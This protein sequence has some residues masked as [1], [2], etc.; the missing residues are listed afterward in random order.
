MNNAD[1]AI[2]VPARLASSRFPRKLLHPVRGRPIMLWTARR[3]ATEAPGLPLFFAVAEQELADL[4]TAHGYRAILTDPALPSGTDRLAEAN[5]EIGAAWLLNVQSDEPLVTGAQIETLARLARE[6]GCDLATLAT[7]FRDPAAFAD[8]NRVKV[9]LDRRGRA[10]YFSRS[11][12]PY[13]RDRQGTVDADWL[14]TQPALLHLGL[15]A[16]SAA[17]L[18][19][20]RTLPPGRLESLERLEQLRALENG[21]SIAV[22][23]SETPT[24][25][26]DTP[27]DIPR[28]ET[29]LARLGI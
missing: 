17:F 15:Y 9:I 11:P 22:G 6:G 4:L 3:V 20:F 10:L 7:P 19:K 23:V 21:F 24:V 27:D 13:P 26:I 25:G 16:Y 29:E 12:I 14:A 5:R 1:I 2:V 8:P 18:E 28:F